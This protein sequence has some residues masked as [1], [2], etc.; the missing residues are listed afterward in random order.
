MTSSSGQFLISAE[1][2]E[3]LARQ[4]Q[5]GSCGETRKT[6]NVPCYVV[7]L[8]HSATATRLSHKMSSVR[9]VSLTGPLKWRW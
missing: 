7:Q 3:K 2:R 4:V 6:P 8:S 9:D 1:K 5:A